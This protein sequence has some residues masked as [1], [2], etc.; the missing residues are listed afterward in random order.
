MP[1]AAELQR[2]HVGTLPPLAPP[3]QRSTVEVYREEIAAMRARGME[4]AAIRARLEERHSHPVSYSAVWRLV[5]R[6]EPASAPE[7]LCAWRSKPAARRRWTLA[8]PGS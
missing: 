3:Q 6:L 8:I 7:P 5:R 1:T 2:L 4:L